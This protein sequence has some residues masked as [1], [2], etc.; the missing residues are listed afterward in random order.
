MEIAMRDRSTLAGLIL[1]LAA[2]I[3]ISVAGAHATAAETTTTP[4]SPQPPATQTTNG[5]RPSTAQTTPSTP[6]Q[7]DSTRQAATDAA[8]T[9]EVKAALMADPDLKTQVI[10]VDTV[11]ATVTL[12]GIVDSTQKSEAARTLVIRVKGVKSVDNRLSVKST[13]ALAVTA[14]RG[15]AMAREVL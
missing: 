13:T 14:G 7:P 15:E 1:L 12:S 2:A 4:Q 10:N 8:I 5:P 9:V 11:N 3:W 6:A